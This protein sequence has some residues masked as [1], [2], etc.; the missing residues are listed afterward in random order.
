MAGR[1]G[2]AGERVPAVLLVTVIMAAVVGLSFLFAFGNVW[3]LALRLGV[4]AYVAPLVAPAVDLTVVGLLVGTRFLAAHGASPEQLRPAGRLLVFASL[5]TLA[6]NVAEPVLAGELGKAAFDSVGCWLLIG[7][8]HIGP[9]L[10]QAMQEFVRTGM[11]PTAEESTEA[12]GV[13]QPEQAVGSRGGAASAGSAATALRPEASPV[14]ADVVC[15]PQGHDGGIVD[16]GVPDVSPQRGS[17]RGSGL[18]AFDDLLERARLEDA[19]Y[20]EEYRR[21]ISAD[22][23]R[24]RLKIG[25]KRAWNLVELVRADTQQALEER[26]S[27]AE[28]PDIGRAAFSSDGIDPNDGRLVDPALENPKESG[29]LVWSADDP[30]RPMRERRVVAVRAQDMPAGSSAAHA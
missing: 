1:D 24:R 14:C 9:G 17:G 27:I 30:A 2:A 16:A 3:L 12:V 15:G 6:L 8:A 7:W 21:P 23:L 29:V 5:V 28:S 13:D 25:S 4:P 11:I 20:W 19:R 18:V 22:E 10:L 26:M